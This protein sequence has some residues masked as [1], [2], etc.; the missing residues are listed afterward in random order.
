[1]GAL[2]G[3]AP[4]DMIVGPGNKYVAEA[5]RQLFGRVGIDLLAGPTEILIIADE[6]ADPVMVAADLIGQ[7]EHDPV[8]RACLVTT[9][10]TLGR[11]VL[12]EIAAQMP[13][14]PTREVA[15]VAWEDNGEVVV[16]GSHEEAAQ[17][18]D[19]WAP[20]HL[21]VQ[22]AN[23]RWYLGRLRNYG[24]LFLGEP[25]TVL[26]SDKALGTNHTLPTLRAARYTGGLWVGKFIKTVTYQIMTEA[27]SV[28]VAPAAM[29]VAEAEGMLA[30]VRTGH[31]RIQKY[32]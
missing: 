18:A 13:T 14:V 6:T 15:A 25:S 1:F 4:T 12:A 19:R 26:Y 5:K 11:A 32:G 16:V 24:S 9:S 7:A 21:E 28:A 8:S 31:M 23:W 17:E 22:T 3:L 30:H 20:E 2:P 10:E 27:G 29:G